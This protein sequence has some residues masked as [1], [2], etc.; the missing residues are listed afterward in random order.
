MLLIQS[1][2]SD[3]V[4]VGQGASGCRPGLSPV[5]MVMPGPAITIPLQAA[6]LNKSSEINGQ[7]LHIYMLFV[8]MYMHAPMACIC[9]GTE[10]ARTRSSYISAP[11]LLLSVDVIHYTRLPRQLGLCY[12]D[13]IIN[14]RLRKHRDVIHPP[15]GAIKRAAHSSGAPQENRATGRIE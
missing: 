7:Q 8:C 13:G 9:L 11:R 1:V 3:C 6:N 2:N 12:C 14:V 5:S 10:N 15:K 4:Y